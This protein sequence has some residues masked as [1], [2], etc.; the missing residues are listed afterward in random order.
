M[1]K[2]YNYPQTSILFQLLQTVDA[3]KVNKPLTVSYKLIKAYGFL[4]MKI[5]PFYNI[6]VSTLCRHKNYRRI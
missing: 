5:K 4:Q 6:N 2:K 1:K 3:S